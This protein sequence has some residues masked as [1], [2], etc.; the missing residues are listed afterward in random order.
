MCNGNVETLGR[1]V[2]KDSIFYWHFNSFARKK[3]VFKEWQ[4]DPDMPPVI[5]FRKPGEL[6]EWLARVA[7]A[8]AGPVRSADDPGH[9]LR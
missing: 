8:A 7:T 4:S 9:A 5:A 3:R 1:L 6:D 2:A